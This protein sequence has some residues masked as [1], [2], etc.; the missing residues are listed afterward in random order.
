MNKISDSYRDEMNCDFAAKRL[1]TYEIDKKAIGSDLPPPV[2]DIQKYI[3][4][5]ECLR[6]VLYFVWSTA[7]G[8]EEI[9][10]QTGQ[11][12]DS[13]ISKHLS[14]SIVTNACIDSL[15]TFYDM[16]VFSSEHL[17]SFAQEELWEHFVLELILL[18]P[19]IAVREAALQQ[20]SQIVIQCNGNS[21]FVLLWVQFMFN[22]LKN[23][24]PQHYQ[25]SEQ[26]FKLCFKLLQNS[27]LRN[28]SL[29]TEFLGYEIE[30]LS[31]VRSSLEINGLIE[32]IQLEGHLIVMKQLV[33]LLDASSKQDV[34]QTR[35]HSNRNFIEM[36]LFD[37]VFSFSRTVA[38]ER[39]QQDRYE[40]GFYESPL[41]NSQRFGFG[42]ERL[43]KLSEG[44]TDVNPVCT[45]SATLTAAFELLVAFSLGCVPNLKF[46][47]DALDELLHQD[48]ENN[49]QGW[50]F[51]PPIG[52]RSARGF[53]G[54][55]NAGATCYM[56]SV[57]QQVRTESFVSDFCC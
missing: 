54:L 46:I 1:L 32:E 17:Q 2:L 51:L 7:T 26:F 19:Q 41:Q 34:A 30:L 13:H 21:T 45:S 28:S 25:K 56:N 20:F 5:M 47:C 31:N 24:V 33:M 18:S 52:P 35:I 49:Q 11:K 53:V 6:T 10:R 22:H 15:E 48:N 55:K 37:F 39:R 14:N 40:T 8:N 38:L 36:L 42:G 4:T 9:L 44:E 16:T 3:P 43:D 27:V 50:E 57:L 23:T 12:M 29:A